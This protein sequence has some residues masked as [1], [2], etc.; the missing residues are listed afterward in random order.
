MIRHQRP[1]RRARTRHAF[2]LVEL[3]IVVT[4]IGMLASIA[5]PR[6]ANAS[7]GAKEAALQATLANVRKAIDV[8]YAEHGQYPGYNY[9]TGL[10]DND[11]FVDQLLMYS[12]DAG[13]TNATYSTT[14]KYGPYL[15]APF[16]TNPINHLATVHVKASPGNADP[17]DGSV[18]WIA[19]LSHGYFG[20]HA[21]DAEL[22]DIGVEDAEMKATL[23]G[24]VNPAS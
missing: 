9:T 21:T 18:G 2:S 6:M 14:Y 20:I 11:A 5:V 24:D 4:I 1:V 13:K 16:P 17:V 19:V 15:R 8:Y 3:V 7:S 22:D 10:P 23:K 12:D